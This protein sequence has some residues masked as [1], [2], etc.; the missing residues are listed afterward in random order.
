MRI[1]KW[2]RTSGSY[3]ILRGLGQ[4]VGS[5]SP[6]TSADVIRARTCENG[7]GETIDERP[8]G[9]SGL[10]HKPDVN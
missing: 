9:L 2:A 8:R 5:A 3:T 6:H 7:G 4:E 10:G 1:S